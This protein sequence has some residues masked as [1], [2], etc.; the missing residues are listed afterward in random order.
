MVLTCGNGNTGTGTPG[1][2]QVNDPTQDAAAPDN[3]ITQSETSLAAFGS[4]ILFGFNDSNQAAIDGNLSGFAFSSDGGSTWSD[5]GSLP[6]NPGVQN[7]GDPVIAVD[8][9]GVFYYGHLG[10]TSVSPLQGIIQVTT[11]TVNPL[12]RFI[13]VRNPFVAGVGSNANT[14]ADKEWITV[15]QDSSRPGQQSL[16]VTW[17]EFD[18]VNNTAT[19]RFSKWS[20]GCNPQPLIAS[21]NVTINGIPVSGIQGSF[22]LVDNNGHLY[23]FYEDFTFGQTIFDAAIRVVKSTD[24]GQTFFNPIPTG[25]PISPV[26]IINTTG[27]CNQPAIEVAPMKAIR[28]NEFPQAAVGPDNTLYVVWN[29]FETTS[30]DVKLA[31]S[32]DAGITWN[33]RD[34]ATSSFNEFFPSVAVNAL[35]AHVQYSRFVDNQRFALFK[36][37]FDRIN[38]TV[39]AETKLST[40]VPDSLVPDTNPNFDTAVASCYMGDYNQIIAGPGTT[41]YHGWSDNRNGVNIINPDVFFI[42]S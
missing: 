17:T 3:N 1:E 13:E 5:C 18:F 37:T 15:G 39:S 8:S 16:Y 27:A 30:L 25:N 11:A 32:T 19:L 7:G 6:Q 34:I 22:P 2:R 24:G 26:K 10:I 21:K 12:T 35:G 9:Q 33:L 28:M 29:S 14:F 31:F 23:I 42:Q 40:A 36:R 20:T 38:N 41:L 4:F